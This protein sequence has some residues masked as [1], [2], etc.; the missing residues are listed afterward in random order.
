MGMDADT[1][2]QPTNQV[3]TI[4][5]VQK[6]GAVSWWI[7]R[8]L[9]VVVLI[10]IPLLYYF[11]YIS[12]VWLNRIGI[13]LNFCAGFLVAPELIGSERLSRGRMILEIRAEQHLF[14]KPLLEKL[15]AAQ[16]NLYKKQN[17]LEKQISKVNKL[18]RDLEMNKP[19]RYT[20]HYH[21]YIKTSRLKTKYRLIIHSTKRGI[22]FIIYFL[23]EKPASYILSRL[24]DD[25]KLRAFLVA[26]GIIF[27]IVGNLLQFVSTF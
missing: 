14:V 15:T 26:L 13:I 9:V 27:F 11:G 6:S 24:T 10:A 17:E 22:L 23:T 7:N 4:A 18:T 5:P 16:L 20:D 25:V 3:Q 8:V 2:Q 12:A 1:V 19:L 21:P